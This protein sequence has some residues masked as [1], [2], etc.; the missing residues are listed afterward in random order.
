M[1][2]M[3]LD[4]VTSFLHL[5][6]VTNT[7]KRMRRSLRIGG[8]LRLQMCF[9]RL[10][11]VRIEIDQLQSEL[12]SNNSLFV[13]LL[14]EDKSLAIHARGLI[15]FTTDRQTVNYYSTIHC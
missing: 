2:F 5:K 4:S 14:Y 1:S 6:D 8:S 13:S 9:C 12:M 3:V 10:L 15:F 7:R 11:C